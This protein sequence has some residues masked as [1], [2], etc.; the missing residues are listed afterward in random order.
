MPLDIIRIQMALMLCRIG[1][2]SHRD[3]SN[4]VNS[5]HEPKCSWSTPTPTAATSRLA[6]HQRHEETIPLFSRMLVMNVR[7]NEFTFGTV[8][9]SAIARKDLHSGKQLH[10]CRRCRREMLFRK[11]DDGSAATNIAAVGMGRSF[12]ACAIKFLGKYGVCVGNSLVRLYAKCG[13]MEDSLWVF[14]RFPKRNVVSW[15]ALICGYAQNGRGKE[16]YVML[17]NAL[18]LLRELFLP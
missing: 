2:R 7:P 12:H 13:S 18:Y 8:I 9:H 1:Q 14:D 4:I 16:A 6:Q 11:R 5:D 17:S 3:V 10:A 15:N